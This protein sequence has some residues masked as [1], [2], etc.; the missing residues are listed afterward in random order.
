MC[1]R[2][3]TAVGP[4]PYPGCVWFFQNVLHQPDV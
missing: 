2:A 1:L 4:P 3:L